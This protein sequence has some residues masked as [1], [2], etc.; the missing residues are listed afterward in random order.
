MQDRDS[1]VF[2]ICKI[3]L[4]LFVNFTIVVFE[5]TLK[6]EKTVSVKAKKFGVCVRH[7]HTNDWILSDGAFEE[8]T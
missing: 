4:D 1:Q 8:D 2:K 6:G 7:Y 3:L 5:L